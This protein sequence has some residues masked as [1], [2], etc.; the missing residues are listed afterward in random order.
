MHMGV[1]NIA[2]LLVGL[3]V[4]AEVDEE[5]EG[6]AFRDGAEAVGSDRWLVHEEV[7]ASVFWAELGKGLGKTKETG[8]RRQLGDDLSEERIAALAQQIPVFLHSSLSICAFQIL[9]DLRWK[10]ERE[11]G[12]RGEM[13]S[14][15]DEAVV[16]ETN[17]LFIL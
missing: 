9:S 6:L 2:L 11:T 4:I 15:E 12:E 1:Q 5:F 8:R 10:R 16:V 13:E 7:L 3:S 14:E 17:F